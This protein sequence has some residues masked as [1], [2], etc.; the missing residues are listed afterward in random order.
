MMGEFF[1]Q[2]LRRFNNTYVNLAAK[3][4]LL[5]ISDALSCIWKDNDYLDLEIIR[6]PLNTQPQSY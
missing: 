4:Y 3:S 1:Q 5:L 6:L 2:Y